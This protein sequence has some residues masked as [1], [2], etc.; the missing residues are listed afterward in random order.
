MKLRVGRAASTREPTF[1]RREI[2]PCSLQLRERHAHRVARGL[3]AL[4]QLELGGQQRAD[5]GP[6]AG[7]LLGEV[8]GD[9]RVLGLSHGGGRRAKAAGMRVFPHGGYVRTN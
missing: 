2:R 5:R 4:A 1:L 6:P 7:D 8:A 3:V 9:L